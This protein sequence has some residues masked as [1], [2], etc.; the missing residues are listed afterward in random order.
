MASSSVAAKLPRLP[1]VE[2]T[3]R[4]R[5]S[6]RTE[7]ESVVAD[8]IFHL[9]LRHAEQ[10]MEERSDPGKRSR[11]RMP[12]AGKAGGR[13]ATVCA[14]AVPS[15]SYH[16]RVWTRNCG[17]KRTGACSPRDERPGKHE[18]EHALAS[19]GVERLRADR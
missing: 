3:L 11:G 18:V 5:M 19:L 13:F 9:R 16:S 6:I 10:R 2:V 15:A 1:L 4:S 7:P 12:K 17:E 14:V 8:G